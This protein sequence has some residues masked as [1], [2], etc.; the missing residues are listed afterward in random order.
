[1]LTFQ[2][3][4]QIPE[5]TN[6]L[7]SFFRK[8]KLSLYL[9]SKGQWYPEN[10]LTLDSDGSLPVFAMTAAGDI[11][12]RA[13][14]ISLSGK[15]T[16]EIIKECIPNIN[17]PEVIPSVDI[18]SILLAIRLAS[19]GDDF[20]TQISVPNTKL[21]RNIKLSLSEL[22]NEII[23]RK[24]KWDENI[25]IEDETCQKISL[26]IYPISLKYLFQTSKNINNQRKIMSKNF[27]S[28]DNLKDESAFV[29][30]VNQLTNTAI[31]LLCASIKNLELIDKDGNIIASFVA[32]N[33]QE[34][35]QISNVVKS[36]DIEYFNAIRN[37]LE[38]QRKKYSYITP[39]QIS[40]QKEL[41]AGAPKE[42]TAEITFMGSSFLPEQNNVKTNI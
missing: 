39:I 35:S 20:Q 19:Y 3:I 2:H 9:P 14:D 24:D 23:S 17:N 38:G 22:L 5:A 10:S 21:T 33:P 41:I 26:T 34:I 11:K 4:N 8:K 36:M 6:P 40:T 42:W 32:N 7:S 18:D 29:N 16:Y 25:I 13:G 37:H 27:D 31:E 12:F 1:M 15:S 28:D 30:S